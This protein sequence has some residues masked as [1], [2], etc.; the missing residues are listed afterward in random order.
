MKG[1]TGAQPLII[2]FQPGERIPVNF[3]LTGEAFEL[4]P[5]NPPLELVVKKHYFLRIGADG[6]R[7]SPDPEHFDDKPKQPGS[8]QIGFWVDPSQ[9]AKVN[10]LIAAP[11]P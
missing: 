2:E 9:H 6:F 11:R 7:M 3:E 5:R 8:F 10:V 1:F 4:Q